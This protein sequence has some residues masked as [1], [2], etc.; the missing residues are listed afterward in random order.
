MKQTKKRSKVQKTSIQKDIIALL[1]ILIALC[2]IPLVILTKDYQTNFSQ[3][4]WFTETE[5]DQIDSFESAKG[6]CVVVM[7]VI[8]AAVIA[9]SEYMQNRKKKRIL[10]NCDLKVCILCAVYCAMVIISSVTSKYPDLAYDGGGYGQ[11]QTM[12]VLL[13]YAMLFLYAYVFVTSERRIS[14]LFRFFMVSTGIITLIGVLQGVGHNPIKWSWIQKIITSQSKITELG[15][16]EGF[17]EV[18]M[19]FNNPN[20]VGP[21]I[22]LLL[23]IVIAFVL[24]RAAENKAVA[25]IW[26]ILG[27]LVAVGL[28]V[29][30]V[31]AGSSAGMLAVASGVVFVAV[32]IISGFFSKEKKEKEKEE[33]GEEKKSV[34]NYAIG[35]GAVVVVILLA[36]V[37]SRTTLFESTLNKLLEGG[38]DTRNVA[39]IVNHAEELQVELRNGSEFILVPIL[40]NNNSV[41]FQAFDEKNEPIAIEW[42]QEQDGYILNDEHYNM[43]TLKNVN[44][45]VGENVYPGFRFNDT[46]NDISW[47]FMNVD[48]EWKYYTPFGKFTK[49]KKIRHFG[50]ENYQNIANRRGFIWSRTIPLMKDYWFKGIG[51]NAFIIAFPNNDFVGSKR[52]G[53]NTTLVDKPHNT[54]LQV[55]VQTGGISALAYLGLG[56]LYMIGSIRLFWRRKCRTNLEKLG[57]GLCTGIFA[58]AVASLTN[59]GIVGTQVMYWVLLGTGYAINRTLRAEL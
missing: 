32:L 14:L 16:K 15:F 33:G 55:Y 22:A 47:I 27:S 25:W 53:G 18:I 44:F 1:P 48:N 58:F 4:D 21:Y 20:Y 41:S 7:G 31:G 26:R 38:E 50:F 29:S 12:W 36:V 11:W 49:L 5:L 35:G 57:L 30:L 39:S 40:E 28:V 3:Y 2:L 43:I 10:E 59:D 51:P 52:I 9:I 37:I 56:L 34:R 6:N 24:T 8:A 45:S 42:S 17:A 13:G 23:P 19:T 54:F 46:P